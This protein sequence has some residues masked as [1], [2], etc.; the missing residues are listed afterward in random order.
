MNSPLG[1]LWTEYQLNSTFRCY[2]PVNIAFR[3]ARIPDGNSIGWH[4][5][6]TKAPT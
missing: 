1:R 4:S 3:A 6:A 5:H 2:E